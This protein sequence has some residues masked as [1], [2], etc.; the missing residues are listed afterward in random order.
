MARLAVFCSG[1]G[2]NF[3]AL[4]DAVHA[5][6]LKA[7][8]AL[9]VCDKPGAYALTR[10]KKDNISSFVFEP[11]KFPSRELYERLIMREMTHRSVDVVVLAGFMRIFTP[12]FIDAYK[13]RILNIHP[14]FLPEFKGA[15]AIR[16]AFQAKVKETGVTVHVVV[17]EVDAG[18]V[19]RQE[20][21]PV[22]PGDTLESLEKRIHETEHR[23]YPEAIQ[24]FISKLKNKT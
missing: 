5:G 6:K 8:I 16:D 14:S 11:K 13:G 1:Y 20:R 19:I 3:Q 21:V 10:A 7:E 17:D 22:M 9:M 4:I 15:H 2:S 12:Y 18:P 24:D 23:I